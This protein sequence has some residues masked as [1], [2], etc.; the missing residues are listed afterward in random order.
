MIVMLVYKENYPKSIFIIPNDDY[1]LSQHHCPVS[2]N[3]ITL[4]IM[5]IAIFSYPICLLFLLSNNAIGNLFCLYFCRGG[6]KLYIID[7]ISL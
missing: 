5:P 7:F 6:G 3:I 2:L 4:F 1:N